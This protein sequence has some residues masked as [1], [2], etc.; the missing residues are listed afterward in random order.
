[1]RNG[2]NQRRSRRNSNSGGTSGNQRRTNTPNRNQSF[3][4]NGPDVRIRGNAFQVSEKYLALGRDAAAAGDRVLAENYYQHA[5]HYLRIINAWN[6]Q[7]E[8]S[9]REQ[10]ERRTQRYQ[11]GQ[12]RSADDGGDEADGAEA[13]V[14]RRGPPPAPANGAEGDD[15]HVNGYSV[16]GDD[17]REEAGS[18]QPQ[19]RTI[20]ISE[21]NADGDGDEPAQAAEPAPRP[22]RRATRRRTQSGAAASD[23]GASANQDTAPPGE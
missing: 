12:D 6:E 20:E 19:I 2:P 5:E 3:D 4:S 8:E 18:G 7:A 13:V 15:G 17:P 22:R 9:R 1:M 21:S 14:E 10:Q 16:L 23:D 11:N